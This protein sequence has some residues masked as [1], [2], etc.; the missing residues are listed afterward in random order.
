MWEMNLFPFMNSHYSTDNLEGEDYEFREVFPYTDNDQKQQMV[1]SKEDKFITDIVSSVEQHQHISSTIRLQQKPYLQCIRKAYSSNLDLKYQ[2]HSIPFS[3]WSQLMKEQAVQSLLKLEVPL[4]KVSLKQIY[5]LLSHYQKDLFNS[6]M[7]YPALFKGEVHYGENPIS[8]TSPSQTVTTS[9]SFELEIHSNQKVSLIFRKL[10]ATFI[11][12]GSFKSW[13][14]AYPL[15]K[16]DQFIAYSYSLPLEDSSAAQKIMDREEHY[17]VAFNGKPHIAKIYD[18]FY[19]TILHNGKQYKQQVITMKYYPYDLF[20]IMQTEDPH[21]IL[22]DQMRI[23]YCIQMAQ[24]VQEVHA[25]NTIHRDLKLENFLVIFKSGKV[26]L[27]DFG[28]ACSQNDSV[29]CVSLVGTP[30]TVAPEGFSSIKKNTSLDIWALGCLFWIILSGVRSF[31]PWYDEVIKKKRDF[32]LIDL[33]MFY[34]DACQPT[35]K[36]KI[37]FLLWNMM[38]YK[39]E[40]RWN[41]KKVVDYLHDLEKQLPKEPDYSLPQ[42]FCTEYKLQ[43]EAIKDLVKAE[44]EKRKKLKEE[45]QFGLQIEKNSKKMANTTAQNKYMPNSVVIASPIKSKENHA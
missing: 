21:F 15:G 17:W 25:E 37:T 12:N 30:S 3:E 11:E 20:R 2:I 41:I 6:S 22:T 44:L 29:A 43:E 34:Y 39:S 23:R 9:T 19:Y 28:L 31:Y 33:N 35:P 5:D 32:E 36:S 27:T 38:R 26:K 24:G 13:I 1:D 42:Q 18:I 4:K 10:E 7:S 40:N 8:S 16:P 45:K 14:R